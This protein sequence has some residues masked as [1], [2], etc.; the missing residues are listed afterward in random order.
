MAGFATFTCSIH[1]VGAHSA[2]PHLGK[3]PIEIGHEML[4]QWTR[5][6]KTL[7]QQLM[8]NMEVTQFQAGT[9]SNTIPDTAV[10]RGSVRCFDDEISSRIKADMQ[11]VVDTL[12]AQFGIS[13]SFDYQTQYPVLV[14]DS[15]R[16]SYCADVAAKLV[17]HHR[18]ER[19]RTPLM[20]SEDFACMLQAKPGAY[21]LIGNGEGNKGGC[22]VHNPHYDFNDDIL[23][24]GA[25]YFI[26]LVETS[27]DCQSG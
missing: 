12:S 14:N 17:G 11:A 20:A 21:I 6:K 2:M 24:L 13:I 1:G 8:I 7:Q 19:N 23:E 3:N 22:M 18:V 15:E 5:I 9:T 16:V 25:N 4:S 10:I 26:G 27:L